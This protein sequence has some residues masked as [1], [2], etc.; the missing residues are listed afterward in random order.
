MQFVTIN[1]N[2]QDKPG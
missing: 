2:R 1:N